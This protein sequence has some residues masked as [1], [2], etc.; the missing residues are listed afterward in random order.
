MKKIL[1]P[2]IA[3]IALLT[4]SSCKKCKVADCTLIPAKIIRYDCDKVIFQLLTNEGI[5]DANWTDVQTGQ[6]YS[7]VVYYNNTCAIAA[8][9]KGEKVTL[10]VNLKKV[11][12]NIIPAGCVQCQAISQSPPTTQVDM[13]NISANPCDLDGK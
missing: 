7:N 10:Y 3:A 11:T 9:S 6:N 4:V 12:T 8:L 1:F 5:G 2:L 13:T